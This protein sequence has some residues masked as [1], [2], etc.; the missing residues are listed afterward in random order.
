MAISCLWMIA[1]LA[2]HHVKIVKKSAE[3]LQNLMKGTA[4]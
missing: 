4:N 3:Q 2:R 1:N